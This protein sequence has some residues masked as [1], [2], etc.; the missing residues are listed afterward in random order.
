MTSPYYVLYQSHEMLGRPQ[1]SY[2]ANVVSGVSLKEQ[3]ATG[4]EAS[5]LVADAVIHP[6]QA[7]L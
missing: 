3:K 6:T 4:M 2:L 1:E 7:A 5:I